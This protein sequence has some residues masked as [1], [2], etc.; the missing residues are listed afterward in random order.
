MAYEI[1]PNICTEC[2]ACAFECPNRAISS[3][4]GT[5]VINPNKC[6]EC[7]GKFD[8]PQCVVVCPSGGIK[9]T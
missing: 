5:Y 4:H 9:L 3:K 1:N 2:G 7:A 8:R 6:N